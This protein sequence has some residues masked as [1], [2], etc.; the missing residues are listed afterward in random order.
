MQ[1]IPKFVYAATRLAF[2]PT[3]RIV[4]GQ[5]LTMLTV[6]FLP[7][8]SRTGPCRIP[9]P[10]GRSRLSCHFQPVVRPILRRGLSRSRS[11]PGSVRTSSL[12]IF[13]AQVADRHQSR[14]QRASGWVHVVAGRHQRQRHHGRALQKPRFDPLKSFAPLAAICVDS[15]ALVI[16]PRVPADTFRTSWTMRR[17]IPGN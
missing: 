13:P 9:I 15:M 11:R 3:R 6:A 4:A 7:T 14:R 16:S 5:L 8:A 12:K 17:T 1:N 10:N 2:S